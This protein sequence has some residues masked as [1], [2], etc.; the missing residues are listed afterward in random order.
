MWRLARSVFKY[1]TVHGVYDGTVE[2]DDSN[3]I[4]DGKKIKVR[5]VGLHPQINRRGGFAR[6]QNKLVAIVAPHRGRFAA[7]LDRCRLMWH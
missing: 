2:N 6:L 1:D 5:T 3:L 7:G 4:V